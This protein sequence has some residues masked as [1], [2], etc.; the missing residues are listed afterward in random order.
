VHGIRLYFF[1]YSSS[2]SHN[3]VKNSLFLLYSPRYSTDVKIGI[4]GFD[5][6]GRLVFKCAVEQGVKVVA[7]N[8]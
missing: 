8:G 4:N 6:I 5:D 2:L 7:I 1:S 3:I